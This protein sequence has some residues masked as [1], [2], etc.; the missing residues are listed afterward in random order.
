MQKYNYFKKTASKHTFFLP[1][2]LYF[3]SI[4]F[5]CYVLRPFLP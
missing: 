5:V 4:F 3:S 2:L 1:F